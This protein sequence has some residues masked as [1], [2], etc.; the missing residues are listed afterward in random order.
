MMSH[1]SEIVYSLIFALVFNF[2][3]IKY[4]FITVVHY[5]TQ[6][7]IWRQQIVPMPR[8]F[9]KKFT[10]DILNCRCTFRVFELSRKYTKLTS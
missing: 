3:L 1:Q 9:S 4:F 2:A 6:L 7:G 5:L 8:K 10:I